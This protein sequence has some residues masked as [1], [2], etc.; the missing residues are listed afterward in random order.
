MPGERFVVQAIVVDDEALARRKLRELLRNEPGIQVVGEAGTAAEAIA[1]MK[2]MKPQLVFLD[3]RLPDMD[4][5]ELMD[6]VAHDPEVTRPN[7]IFTTAYDSYALRAF[8]LRAVDYLLK[9]FTA[10]R[11]HS[12]VQRVLDPTAPTTKTPLRLPTRIN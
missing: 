10:E 4:G 7:V 3:V 1:C 8:D 11:L 5:I 9:P 12:A 6:A 2:T